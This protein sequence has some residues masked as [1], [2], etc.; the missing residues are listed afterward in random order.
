MKLE[1]SG[2]HLIGVP[3]KYPKGSIQVANGSEVKAWADAVNAGWVDDGIY[4]YSTPDK[5]YYCPSILSPWIGYWIKAKEEGISLVFLA[6]KGIPPGIFSLEPI[7][8]RLVNAPF[9][10]PSLPPSSSGFRSK[11]LDVWC[12]PNPVLSDNK[13]WFEATL[14]LTPEGEKWIALRDIHVEVYDLSGRLVWNGYSRGESYLEWDLRT[15]CGDL[16]ANGVYLY[17]LWTDI[18][19]EKIV[20]GIGK[21]VVLR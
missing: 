12:S 21:L 15:S 16:L 19:G 10:L 20:S 17:R 5:A 8:D 7:P 3:W 11:Y 1:T 4:G 2:W 9:D 14:K 18:D 13:V 6:S